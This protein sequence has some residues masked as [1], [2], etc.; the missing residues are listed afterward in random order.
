MWRERCGEKPPRSGVRG[1]VNT[2][3]LSGLMSKVFES[4][5]LDALLRNP[6]T[7]EVKERLDCRDGGRGVW[8]WKLDEGRRRWEDD[9]DAVR[10]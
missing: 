9:A 2:L 6:E 1:D 3:A 5:L 4:R 10:D 7:E 8:T